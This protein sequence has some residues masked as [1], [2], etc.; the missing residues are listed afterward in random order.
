MF[1]QPLLWAFGIT[2]NSN[3]EKNEAEVIL[4]LDE[5]SEVA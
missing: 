5:A 4:R 2:H 1:A 3:A